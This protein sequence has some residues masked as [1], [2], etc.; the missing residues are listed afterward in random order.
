MIH[1]C[2]EMEMLNGLKVAIENYYPT[3]GLETKYWHTGDRPY[4]VIFVGGI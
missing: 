2:S 3:L 1:E 4:F